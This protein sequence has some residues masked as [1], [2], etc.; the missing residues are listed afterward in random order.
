MTNQLKA[1]GPYFPI[2]ELFIMLCKVFHLFRSVDV[3]QS[4]A[5]HFRAA[6]Q[7]F[8]VVFSIIPY[9]VALRFKFV[10]EILKYDHSGKPSFQYVS[11]CLSVRS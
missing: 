5:L 6:E 11:V 7:Y 9:K 10:H 1:A 2:V 3:T 8:P 4:V